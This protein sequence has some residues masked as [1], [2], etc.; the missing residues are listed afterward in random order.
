M[1]YGGYQKTEITSIGNIWINEEKN[2]YIG[3]KE[4][5]DILNHILNG[6]T[7]EIQKIDNFINKR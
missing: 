6:K 7:I 5:D 1:S 2:Y 3:L 4:Y